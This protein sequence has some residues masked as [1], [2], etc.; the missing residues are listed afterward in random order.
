MAQERKGGQP[1][2]GGVAS[3]P[4]AEAKRETAAKRQAE[5]KSGAK[6]RRRGTEA[7]RKA[8]ARAAAGA[9][10]RTGA[11][12]RPSAA[13]AKAG[14]QGADAKAAESKGPGPKS[15]P[16]SRK[17]APTA[18]PPVVRARARFVRVAPRKARLIADQVR[19]LGIDDARTLLRFSPRGAAR[20]IAKLIDSAAANAEENHDLVADDLRVA[21]VRVDEGPT[22]RRFRPRALGRATRINKRTSHISVALKPERS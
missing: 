1:D 8:E 22:L 7:G 16:A 14:V 19:G 9:R 15:K 18:A 12:K 17:A 6:P 10:K 2:R 5:A 13:A 3:K 11:K 4:E 21:D 20:D